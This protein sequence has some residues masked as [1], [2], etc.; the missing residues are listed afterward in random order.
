MDLSHEAKY[1]ETPMDLEA[2]E[3]ARPVSGGLGVLLVDDNVHIADALRLK[4]SRSTMFYF[5]GWLADASQLESMARSE[6]PDMAVVDVDMPGPDI[7]EVMGRLTADG[8][9]TRVVVFSGLVNR[10]LVDRAIEAGAWG[11]ASKNDGE[12]EL[13]E[14][15]LSVATGDVA[16][17]TEV[18]A[19]CNTNY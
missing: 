8:L 14:V 5:A 9:D 7:F 17:S 3:I 6:K 19:A 2:L 15:L 12:H 1:S 16:F 11:Y 13:I 18:T 10:E 4:F